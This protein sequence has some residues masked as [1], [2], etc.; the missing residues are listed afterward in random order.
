M[1][2]Y[3]VEKTI[4]L[5]SITE[6]HTELSLSLLSLSLSL[7]LSLPLSLS[8]SLLADTE[9]LWCVKI[10]ICG[11]EALGGARHLSDYFCFSTMCQFTP[12]PPTNTQQ[13]H[14]SDTSA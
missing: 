13:T 11:R 6:K 5:S 4:N 8:L 2:N 12:P 10:E 3:M 14:L 9:G 7:S 1:T